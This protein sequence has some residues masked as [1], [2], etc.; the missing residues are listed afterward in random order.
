[1]LSTNLNLR[2]N[3]LY[4]AIAAQ[5]LYT[6]GLMRGADGKAPAKF[7][8]EYVGSDTCQACTKISTT[9]SEKPAQRF[10]NG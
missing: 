8:D 9:V 5:F 7:G 4:L 6:A 10:R 1:M 2:R 3:C